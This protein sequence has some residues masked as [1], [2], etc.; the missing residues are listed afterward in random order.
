VILEDYDNV[1]C[2]PTIMLRRVGRCLTT[3]CHNE[4]ENK[5]LQTTERDVALFLLPGLGLA[6]GPTVRVQTATIGLAK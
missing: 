2:T 6:V 4:D 3:L 1:M 5:R